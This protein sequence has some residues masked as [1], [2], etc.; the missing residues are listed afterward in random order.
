MALPSHS[1]GAASLASPP[2]ELAPHV[3]DADCAQGYVVLVLVKTPAA[4]SARARTLDSRRTPSVPRGRA[5]LEILRGLLALL[6]PPACPAC[7]ASGP[8]RAG[9]CHACRAA[10]ALSPCVRPP[11]KGLDALAVAAAFRPPLDAWVHRFKYPRAGLAGLDPAPG[12]LMRALALE[13][14][15]RAPGPAPELVV[16][17]ALHPRRLRQRGF[18]PAGELARAIARAHGVPFAPGALRRVRDTPSQTGLSRAARRRN[19]KGA[20]EAPRALHGARVW[21]VDDVVTT[22][23]TLSAAAR[24]LRKAGA[25]RVV[26][27]CA[28]FTPAD[29]GP[30][31][32]GSAR[33][34]SGAR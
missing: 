32:P 13:A 28:A 9:P 14:A 21:L 34:T 7:G 31:G 5:P 27:V 23:S 12:A 30:D 22:G 16:P 3:G 19:V 24:E 6:L 18:H 33:W 25:R 11:P 2:L 20:F 17:I 1:P 4:I 10:L 15:A 8:H 29:P 26:A